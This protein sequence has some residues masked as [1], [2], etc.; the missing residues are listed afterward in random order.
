[1]HIREIRDK[2]G[3]KV[4]VSEAIPNNPERILSVTGPLDAV[5]KAS[6]LTRFIAVHANVLSGLRLDR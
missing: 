3:A 6:L 5:S 1:M 4:G 2:A